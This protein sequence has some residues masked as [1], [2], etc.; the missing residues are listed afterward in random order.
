MQK[1]LAI[2]IL[3]AGLTVSIQAQDALPSVLPAD[4]TNSVLWRAPGDVASL[5]LFAGPGGRDTAPQPPFVYKEAA[6]V[7]T[8]P[9]IVAT[10]ARNQTWEV[11]WGHEVKAEPFAVRL[12]W[13][14]G[15]LVEP[16][17]FVES[18]QI[19]GAEHLDRGDPRH[20]RRASVVD[21]SQGNAFSHARFEL[22]DPRATFV[23][24][25]AWAWD[26]NPFVGSKE[27]AGLRVMTML[28]SNTDTKDANRSVLKVANKEG[29]QES[30]FIV[31]DWG[32]S[33]GRWGAFDQK[34]DCQAYQQQT[35]EFVKG[36][37]KNGMVRFGYSSR[38]TVSENISP[39]DVRW[40]MTYLGQITDQQ[41]R[42]G[43]RASNASP[44]EMECFTTAVR[45][46]IEQ[47]RAIAGD[48]R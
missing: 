29:V 27:L 41:L 33:M 18:G 20:D 6:G 19:Q 14:V 13:A 38:K 22:R 15:Y 17:Y 10:D 46:R 48:A 1:P 31:N 16:S 11:K 8:N 36:I 4:E 5:D 32:A 9:K 23:K 39:S 34:W 40:L 35:P 45:A 43:L 47:L 44:T 42:D 7:G 12:L 37:D 3:L 24:G 28:V 2:F 25:S 21:R 26:S 30:H